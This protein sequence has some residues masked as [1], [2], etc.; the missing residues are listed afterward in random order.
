MLALIVSV[1][2]SHELSLLCVS[3]SV[4]AVMPPPAG[5]VPQFVARPVESASA[6]APVASRWNASDVSAVFWL[7]AIVMLC[8]PG[9]VCRMPLA[10]TS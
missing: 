10:A 6:T 7:E 2:G 9:R 4:S 1:I 5:A 8:W 3:V